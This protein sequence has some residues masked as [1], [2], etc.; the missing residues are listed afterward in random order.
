MKILIIYWY[1]KYFF[2]Y[3]QL[4]IFLSAELYFI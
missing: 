2:V 4:E 3:F 1:N